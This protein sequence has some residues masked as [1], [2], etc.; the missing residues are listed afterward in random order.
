MISAYLGILSIVTLI[1]MHAMLAQIEHQDAAV[2]LT[3]LSTSQKKFIDLNLKNTVRI[4]L[5]NPAGDISEVSDISNSCE[6]KIHAAALRLA[7]MESFVENYYAAKG[8]E[9]N[10]WSGWITENNQCV[11]CFDLITLQSEQVLYCNEAGE[12]VV[13]RSHAPLSEVIGNPAIGFT[14]K[15]GNDEWNSIIGEGF[16]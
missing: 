7:E 9:V 1:A 13:S 10:A 11:A 14:V 3:I 12:V 15:R 8:M 6:E 16:E 2:E 5:H 4:A